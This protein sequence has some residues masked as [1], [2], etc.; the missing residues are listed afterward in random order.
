MQYRYL[1]TA[2]YAALLLSLA[3]VGH[4]AELTELPKSEQADIARVCLPVQYREGAVAYRDCV[5]GEVTAREGK[6]TAPINSL[7]F[8]DQYAIQQACSSSTS[9]DYQ[10]CVDS[11][12][13]EIAAIP[14]PLIDDLSDDEQ[15]ALQQTCFS[16]QT[17]EGV[18]A[19][20]TCINNAVTTLRQL[21]VANLGSLS[22][23]ERNAL[24]LRC[25]ANHADA[26]DY[27]RCLLDATVTLS[28]PD[29]A[30]TNNNDEESA[31]RTTSSDE[32]EREVPITTATDA[33]S[34]TVDAERSPA[35]SASS[36]AT[37]AADLAATENADAI[38]QP[39]ITELPLETSGSTPE[40]GTQTPETDTEA[41][42][43]K[44]TAADGVASRVDDTDTQTPIPDQPY[45]ST[46]TASNDASPEASAQNSLTVGV[47]S[48]RSADANDDSVLTRLLTTVA[49]LDTIGKALLGA[50]LLLPL[51]FFGTWA[52][53]R[54][55]EYEEEYEVTDF[56]SPM[57][58]RDAPSLH[59]RDSDRRESRLREEAD[60][61][62]GESSALP[63]KRKPFPV[64]A[65]TA[66]QNTRQPE[67]VPIADAASSAKRIP[68]NN[69][70][71]NAGNEMTRLAVKPELS[72]RQPA[73]GPQKTARRSEFGRWL[74][75]QEPDLQLQYAIEFLIYWMA[76]GDE[77]YDPATK[78]SLFQNQS[79][80]EHDMIKRWVLQED[81]LAFADA[82]SWMQDNSTNRQR[83]QTIDLLMALLVTDSA[84]TPTQNVILR[85]LGDVFGLGEKTMGARYSEAFGEPLPPIARVDK[86]AW[87]K[88]QIK[89]RMQGWDAQ[90]VAKRPDD[91]QHR[92]RLG[93]EVDANLDDSAIAEH[94]RRAAW[95]CHPDRF[96]ALGD[97]ERMLAEHQY[98]K[99][100]MARD[101][102]LEVRT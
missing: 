13:S 65:S 55:R 6:M 86:P 36:Q 51:L 89:A 9:S 40:P 72:Y 81:V 42:D 76:Y 14:E 35:P 12:I 52:T 54:R 27:R 44:T 90:S 85:F 46:D 73:T 29:P 88:R 17:G 8:D 71:Q 1:I 3:A 77:R 7:S 56:D 25:S 102:L 28:K 61:L 50:A 10:K 23:L 92:I 22:L 66:K 24:Q 30:I 95:R 99:L 74:T 26:A 64:S 87:W 15:Y 37:D 63:I 57:F 62:F 2:L 96:D 19:Y 16:A 60:D 70:I 32:P 33:V 58:D 94:F 39:D 98:E 47:A 100:E 20:R 21:P 80:N 38:L 31:A 59:H 43:D 91:E 69:E 79:L 75:C 45:S 4:A 67:E 84:L 83:T 49:G 11:Q 97:R 101:Q 93:L 41:D 78:A 34:T 68:E 18:A 82:V 5:A 53:S 48:P